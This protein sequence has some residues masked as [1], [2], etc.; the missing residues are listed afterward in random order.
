MEIILDVVTKGFDSVIKL[1]D[2][3]MTSPKC[4]TLL[5]VKENIHDTHGLMT[6]SVKTNHI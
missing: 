3:F 6:A 1:K 5:E 4:T 2:S